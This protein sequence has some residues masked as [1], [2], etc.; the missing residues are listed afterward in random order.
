VFGLKRFLL[1]EDS[2]GVPDELV[3]ALEGWR[4][5]AEPSLEEGHFHSRYIVLDLATSGLKPASDVVLGLAASTVH[6]DLVSPG[7]AFYVR[8]TD[9]DGGDG[10]V[11]DGL[12]ARQLIAFLQFSAK[13]PIVTYHGA[14]VGEFLQRA[15]KDRLGLNFQAAWID[16]AWLLPALFPEKWHAIKPFDYW[17]DAFGLDT[18][19]GQRSSMENNLL[20]ARMFQMLLTRAKEKHIDTAQA[21]IQE[22]EASRQLLFNH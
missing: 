9:E 4:D 16:L 20:M 19:S 18:G 11:S 14:F 15:Y 6:R 7:D 22:S 1:K 21:L 2:S 8:S 3:P 5:A 12:D 13:C 17:I 10:K